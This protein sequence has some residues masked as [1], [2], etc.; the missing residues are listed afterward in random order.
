MQKTNATFKIKSLFNVLK[1]VLIA[2]D[3]LRDWLA[4]FLGYML[5]V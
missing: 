3:A 4:S 2:H 5:L 1:N